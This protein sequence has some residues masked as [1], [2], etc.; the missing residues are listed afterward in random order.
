MDAPL[1]GWL[2][3]ARTRPRVYLTL[4]TVSFGAVEVLRRALDDLGPL[5]VDVLVSIGPEGDPALLGQP[6]ANAHVERFVAQSAVLP[7]VDLAVHHGGTG[8]VLGALA[9]GL[10]QLVLPQGADHFFNGQVLDRC[11]AARRLLNEQQEP[12]AIAA[13]VIALL[14]PAASKR[15]VADRIGA[16]SRRC[17]PGGDRPAALRDRRQASWLGWR[18]RLKA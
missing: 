6:P 10:P 3:A 13:A 17:R 14:D 2:S 9:A 18:S 7:V 8:T 16:E 12:G 4:G 11:G 5:D 1:P 15:G